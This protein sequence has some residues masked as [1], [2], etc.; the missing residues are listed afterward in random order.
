MEFLGQGSD[1]SRSLD[2]NHS[3]SNTGFLTHCGGLGIEPATQC[4][5]MPLIP[6]HHSGNSSWDIFK[7]EKQ[8]VKK[9]VHDSLCFREEKKD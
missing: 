7:C 5:K 1:P 3:C 4:T 9:T 2:L 8:K 6:L